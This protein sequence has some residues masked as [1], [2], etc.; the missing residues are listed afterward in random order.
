MKRGLLFVISGP[1]GCGKGTVVSLLEKQHDFAVSVSA[2]T[3]APRDGE[4]DGVHYHFWT[5]ERFEEAIAGGEM[6]EY[7][8]YSGSKKYYGTPKARIAEQLESGRDVILEIEVD[9]AMQVKKRMPEAILI[10]MVPPSMSA[11]RAR[12]IGRGT[13]SADVIEARMNRAYEELK[14]AHGY[15][16]ILVNG[17]NSAEETAQKLLGIATA[18]K[19]RASR[20][21]DFI[22]TLIAEQG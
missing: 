15:D 8:L 13:E 12:L 20:N 9:G 2:T 19:L 1:S 3:R 14:L 22:N 5:A 4:I 11:L 17:E 18:E 10:F 6:L 21:T 16:Y 7:T